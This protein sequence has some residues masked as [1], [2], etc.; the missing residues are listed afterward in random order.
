MRNAIFKLYII[1]VIVF[2]VIAFGL[3]IQFD[4]FNQIL[5]EETRR[6]TTSARDSIGREISSN[7]LRKGQIITDASD[8]ISLD[9]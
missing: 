4:F 8:Y 2:V 3:F 9:F 7:L 6:I 5:T 1:M